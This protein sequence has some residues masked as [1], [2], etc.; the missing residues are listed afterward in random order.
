MQE[1]GA[2]LERAFRLLLE[3]VVLPPKLAR[4]AAVATLLLQHRPDRLA[5]SGLNRVADAAAGTDLHE[6]ERLTRD[7][8][9]LGPTFIKLGQS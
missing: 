8:E 3:W 6:A 9:K 5:P 2:V 7:L 4:Y 1:S